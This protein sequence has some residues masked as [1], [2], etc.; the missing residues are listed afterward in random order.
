MAPAARVPLR[1]V[2]GSGVVPVRL[3]HAA[4]RDGRGGTQARLR[5]R[6]GHRSVR[7]EGHVFELDLSVEASDRSETLVVPEQGAGLPCGALLE[8]GTGGT[9][10]VGRAECCPQPKR[11][12]TA[13]VPPGWRLQARV[14]LRTGLGV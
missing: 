4:W 8:S 11:I 7:R 13:P 10:A 6:L 3:K 9:R 2:S 12:R 1:T 14:P 5:A